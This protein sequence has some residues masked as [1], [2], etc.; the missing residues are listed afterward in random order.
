LILCAKQHFQRNRYTEKKQ[1][2]APR[3]SHAIYLPLQV[4]DGLLAV[5]QQ[6]GVEVRTSACVEQISTANGAVT[7]VQLSGGEWIQAPLVVTNRWA[8]DQVEH[9]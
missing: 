3:M 9:A 1:N 7:G 5:L 8:Y 6:H 4:R 2:L